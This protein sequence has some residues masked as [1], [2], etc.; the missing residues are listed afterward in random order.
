MCLSTYM[1]YSG[2]SYHSAGRVVLAEVKLTNREN[3]KS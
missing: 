1:H 3:H 2:V